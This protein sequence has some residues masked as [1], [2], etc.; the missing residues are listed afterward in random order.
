VKKAIDKRLSQIMCL[1]KRTQVITQ[2]FFMRLC[3]TPAIFHAASRLFLRQ[4]EKDPDVDSEGGFSGI[5]NNNG[6]IQIPNGMKVP[7]HRQT[8]AVQLQTTASSR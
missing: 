8:Q 4:S 7:I 5:L 2:I 1:T 3:Q 6:S